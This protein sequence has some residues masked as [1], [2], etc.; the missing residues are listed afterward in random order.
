[1][2]IH[3]LKSVKGI[4]FDLDGTLVES[5][6]DFAMMRQQIGC[7]PESDLLTYINGLSGADKQQAENIVL[8]HE[9]ADAQSARWIKGAQSFVAM[10]KT[11]AMPMA[12]VTRNCRNASMIKLRNNQVDISL[13][14][15]REDAP[16]KPDP[17]ALLMVAQLWQANPSELAYVGDF[18]YDVLA[19][20]AA[21][22]CSVL[23]APHTIP[24][25]AHQSDI[26]FSDYQ[27]LQDLFC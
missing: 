6:L 8:A 24:D 22:M 21:G 9:M 15:T 5:S 7:P 11:R 14:I 27:Q 17:R 16:A 10:L 4:I 12:I 2:T 18:R 26:V 19:A 25:Y 13:L 20:N 1:M 23:F 3:K